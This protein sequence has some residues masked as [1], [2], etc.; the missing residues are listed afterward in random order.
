[1]AVAGTGAASL[2]AAVAGAAAL[3]LAVV[4]QSLLGA[5]LA[6]GGPVTV[7]AAGAP[8]FSSALAGTAANTVFGAGAPSLSM[9]LGGPSA[10]VAAPSGQLQLIAPLTGAGVIG[11][12][13]AGAPI[14]AAGLTGS[15]ALTV[16]AAGEPDILTTLSGAAVGSLSARGGP[17]RSTGLGGTPSLLLGAIGQPTLR[18][19]L[20]GSSSL[21]VAAA[22]QPVR[23]SAL[24]SYFAADYLAAAQALMPR[25]AAW[26]RE[27]DATQTAVL[28]ALVQCAERLDGDANELLTNL[29]PGTTYAFLEEWE[30]TVGL[31]DM[32]AGPAPTTAKRQRA[33]AAR[34]AGAQSFSRNAIRT[35]CGVLGYDVTLSLLNPFRVN[36]ATVGQRLADDQWANTVTIALTPS[37]APPFSDALGDWDLNFCIAGLRRMAPAHLSIIFNT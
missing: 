11:F 20:S 23:Y 5:G 2:S 35:F 15:G 16:S 13:A 27:P 34:L 9:A 17:A 36:Q 7:T 33:I 29:F 25:G 30:Q 32:V 3:A 8:G 28:T 12:S 26:P 21:L 6:G 31:P 18:A 22:G 1:M 10:L 24:P 14:L 4:G 37:A 19:A